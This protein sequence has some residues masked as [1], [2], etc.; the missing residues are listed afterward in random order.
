MALIDMT[1]QRFGRLTV[2]ERVEDYCLDYYGWT[3]RKAMWRCRCDC[4]AEVTVIG[5]NLRRGATRSCGCLRSD[6]MKERNERKR[7]LKRYGMGVT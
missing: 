6:L 3:D 1:G 4:G 7:Q 5:A 2:L